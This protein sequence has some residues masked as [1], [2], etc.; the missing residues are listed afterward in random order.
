VANSALSQALMALRVSN[1]CTMC[2]HLTQKPNHD[3]PR[4]KRAAKR[5][6]VLGV[7]VLGVVVLGAVDLGG[8]L[9]A[10]FTGASCFPS[11]A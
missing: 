11:G 5:A 4:P 6:V 3:A 8:L 7:A 2:A 9:H 10:Q 1:L